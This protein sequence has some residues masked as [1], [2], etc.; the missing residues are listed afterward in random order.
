[1]GI[2]SP[3]T[4]VSYV[5]LFL[6]RQ[7]LSFTLAR[8]LGLGRLRKKLDSI[9]IPFPFVFYFLL[10]KDPPIPLLARGSSFRKPPPLRLS[11]VRFFFFRST[12]F[13]TNTERL[14]ADR[15]APLSSLPRNVGPAR[16]PPVFF[17]RTCKHNLFQ[18]RSVRASG[19]FNS[20]APFPSFSEVVTALVRLSSPFFL[21]LVGPGT[22]IDFFSEK[23]VP[24][25]RFPVFSYSSSQIFFPGPCWCGFFRQAALFLL[26][27]LSG[28]LFLF[29][30]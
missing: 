4:V 12:P 29:R 25:C 3:L 7:F 15:N 13:L 19:L 22:G 16:A 26:A 11:A 23:R 14:N 6:G 28:A 30:L 9:V 27:V 24:F 1:M 18:R 2:P 5:F 17:F 10:G 8:F 21:L 20:L